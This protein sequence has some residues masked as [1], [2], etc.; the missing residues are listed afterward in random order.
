MIRRPPR[1]TQQSTLFPYTTLFRS[2]AA[3]RPESSDVE[4]WKGSIRSRV[5][6]AGDVGVNQARIELRD[7][8]IV[9]LEFLARRMRRVDDEHVR[10]LG[11]AL[12]NF[13][14]VRRFEINRYPTLVAIVQMP[15]IGILGL[16]LGRNLVP[17]S[18]QFAL[19]RFDF[20]YIGTEV[21]QNDGRSGT[22]HEA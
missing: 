11:Q 19:G 6:V 9:E 13:C 15:H 17:D 3:S 5:A 8:V 12:D 14:R 4:S 16:W 1:S 22:S 18:P 20:D 7:R 2:Q 10:P 21:G